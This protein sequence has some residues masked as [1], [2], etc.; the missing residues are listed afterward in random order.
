MSSFRLSFIPRGC[1]LLFA[2]LFALA[3]GLALW[4]VGATLGSASWLSAL[5]RP[6]P[7]NL[8]QVLLH[9]VLLPRVA[10]ALLCGTALGLA[11]T[12]I[13]QVLRNPLAEPMTLGI[14]PGAYLALALY[15][16]YDGGAAGRELVA[17]V[18]GALAVLVVLALA[19]PQRLSPMAVI[20]CGMVVNLYCGAVS[21]AIALVHFDFLLGLQIWGGGSLEQA[22]WQPSA[23]LLAGL[24]GSVLTVWW[25][26]RPLALLDS[27]ESTARSLG[28]KVE[29]TR[30]VALLVAVVLTALVVAQV[31]VIGFLGL[32]APAL[33]RL[34]GART[35]YQ[36]LFCSAG[37]G[38]AILWATDQV[39]LLIS[40]TQVFSAHLI[41]TGTVTSLLGVPLLVALLPR[42]RS[43]ISSQWKPAWPMGSGFTFRRW[44]WL[45]GL[46]AVGLFLSLAVA[47]GLDGWAIASWTEVQGL[48]FWQVPHT[49]LAMAAGGLLALA[50]TL[51]QRATANPMASPDLLG[52]SS[53]GALGI[54][55]VVFA[56]SQPTPALLFT[57]CLAGSL[58]ALGGLLWLGRGTFTPQ[59]LLLIGVAVS[60]WFQA[61]VSA[62][63]ASGDPRA[64]LMLQLVTG[65][66]Y[67][68]PAVLA[69]AAAGVLVLGLCLVPLFSRW[70]QAFSLG[71]GA[72]ASVGVPVARARLLILLFAGVLTTMA[73]LLVGPLSFIGL[74]APH[75]ARLAGARRP[76]QQ[77][78]VAAL[79]G[80]V[81]MMVSEWLGR[82]MI[83]PQQMPAGLVATLLGGPY[84]VLL[85]L[86]RRRQ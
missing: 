15:T 66:T 43:G 49:V 10:M 45:A 74:L 21:L 80:A 3:A 2:V 12:L 48:L 6:D 35:L 61:M 62:T 36:R 37:I 18:G 67:Y 56:V 53:G 9:E 63:L 11:C 71:E 24:A 70:L 32:A 39:V 5:L 82:Q 16:L 27:G 7:E 86:Y 44:L 59:R 38:A 72:A 28:A 46:L 85:M 79:L 40:T 58:A 84:L 13:Q 41:P 31:G 20:L 64:A 17:L 8:S 30:L 55:V 26:R 4:Q 33:A 75:I 47:R 25:I 29:R 65:S 34:L 52:V 76:L 73:T 51:L 19:W 23:H 50:G 42:L 69:W 83:F 78:W 81:L 60:A 57:A 22:G 14:F 1:L 54:V 77:L 68:I